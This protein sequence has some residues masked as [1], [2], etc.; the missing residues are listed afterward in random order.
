MAVSAFSFNLWPP[1]KRTRAAVV[2]RM[3]KTLSSPSILSKKYGQ[4]DSEQAQV[5]AKKIEEE[6]FSA[7]QNFA[8]TNPGDSGSHVLQ[9][10]S[11]E[12]SKLMLDTAKLHSSNQNPPPQHNNYVFQEGASNLDPQV[13]DN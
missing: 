7:S 5:H 10:Y 4:F 3:V 6:A 2:E 9:F 12:V 13:S 1:S 11:K 8:A